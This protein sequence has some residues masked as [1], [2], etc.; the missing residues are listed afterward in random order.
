MK[1]E[2]N[3]WPLLVFLV[4]SSLTGRCCLIYF[5]Q[6]ELSASSVLLQRL[7]EGLPALYR[8]HSLHLM[9]K[10]PELF[11]VLSNP[12]LYPLLPQQLQYRPP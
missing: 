9:T 10:F 1:I 5:A 7:G 6:T 12:G 11:H 3:P 4:P 8:D 2:T